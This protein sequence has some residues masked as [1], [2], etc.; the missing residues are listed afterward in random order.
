MTKLI[1]KETRDKVIQLRFE[2]NLSFSEV[3]KRAGIGR[4][5]AAQI[6]KEEKVKRERESAEKEKEHEKSQTAQGLEAEGFKRYNQGETPFDLVTSGFAT[7]EIAEDI[8]NK[9]VRLKAIS[10]HP[11]GYKDG[12]GA[13]YKEAKKRYQVG[14]PCCRCGDTILLEKD[15]KIL[16]DLQK[17]MFEAIET[18]LMFVD[19][20]GKKTT[21]DWHHTKCPGQAG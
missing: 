8:W 20:G 6:C 5:K 12:Y 9:F 21:W 19:S 14:I 2:E 18:N 13:G 11:P 17:L 16:A 15:E 10:N 3:A 7:T 1:S 4:S